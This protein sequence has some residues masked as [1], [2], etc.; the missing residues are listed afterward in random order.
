MESLVVLNFRD[1]ILYWFSDEL[2]GNGYHVEKISFE[3]C[4]TI[5]LEFINHYYDNIVFFRLYVSLA[6]FGAAIDRPSRLHPSEGDQN[7]C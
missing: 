4:F 6:L 7:Y 2:R 1:D 5:R 3:E